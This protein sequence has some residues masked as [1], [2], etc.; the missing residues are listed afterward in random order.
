MALE[1]GAVVDGYTIEGVLGSGGMG[2]VY[3]ARHPALPRSDA[4]KVLSAELSRDPHFR[5][6]FER[7]AEL[8]ATLDHPNIVTVYNRGETDGQLWIAMQFVAGSDADNELRDGRMTPARAL[9]IIGEVAKALDYAHRR[10]LLHRDVKPANFLLAPDD[11]RVF[12]ADFGIARALDEAVNLTA[13]GMVMASVAYAAPESLVGEPVDHRADIYS[14]GC[15]LFRLLTGKTP[16]S[17]AGGMGGMAAAHISTPPPRVTDLAPAL[18]AAIDDVI[19]TA[20][21]KDP[22]DRYQ[23]ARELA[24]AAAAAFDET[25]A[26]VRAAPTP[27]IPHG[28]A[29]GR[30][31][32]TWPAPPTGPTAPTRSTGPTAPSGQAHFTAPPPWPGYSGAAPTQAS[33]YYGAPTG[34]T[35]GGGGFGGPPGQFGGPPQSYQPSPPPSSPA[36]GQQRGKRRWLIS[37]AAAALGAA[38]V[39]AGV[40]FWGGG[41]EPAGFQPLSLTHM[42]GTTEIATEPRAVAAVGRGDPDA[43]LSLGVQPAVVVAPAG[44]LPSWEQDLVVG[45][46]RVLNDLDTTAL[47]AADPDLI[48]DSSAIDEDTYNKLAVIAP[49]VTRPQASANWTW[50][51][52]LSWV[53]R[54]LGRSD[55]AKALLDAASSAQA[56]IRSQNPA[57]DGKSVEVVTVGDDGV[58]AALTD[59]PAARYLEGIGF[60]YSTSWRRAATDSGDTRAVADPK[61]LNTAPPDVRLVVRTDAGAGDGSYN[62]LPRPFSTYRGTTIIVDDPTVI[63]ALDNPGY[64]A[65]EHLNET[66]VPTLKRQVH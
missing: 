48:I 11:E 18:P 57:F 1:P 32:P 6:R 17:K 2:T 10:H 41:D 21:A 64:A 60:R 28:G 65:T 19:A 7:E 66:L 58:A 43:V 34:P 47:A 61:Q 25:T 42:Y 38:L 63:T 26:E 40:L 55:K 15:S 36:V 3:R 31:G 39:A 14:L 56:E 24:A 37:G 29:G 45:S 46:V 23:S 5:A 62:G 51:D 30:S 44:G 27:P 53:G 16:F 8:A 52:Q 50:Q 22:A 12:L 20:M 13:T 4:L 35:G 59:S 33:G 49:T 54:T 9:H